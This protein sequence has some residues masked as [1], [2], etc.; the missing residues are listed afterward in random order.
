VRFDATVAGRVVRVEVRGRGPRYSVT[1]EGR[2][3][4]VEVQETST[5]FVDLV[6]DG[7]SHEAGV[8]AREGGCSVLLEGRTLDVLLEEGG[9]APATARRPDGRT[10]RITAPMPGRLLK[11]LV[12]T[13][14]EVTEG[15]GLV[16]MEAMKM[17]NELRAPRAG[18]V[19]ELPALDRQA[20]ESGALL[21][22]LE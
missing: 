8:L 18:R 13:G 7:S 21:V 4:D 10:A 19:K 1:V 5:G 16:V 2:T 17:E 22:V 12:E 20:V 14:Q 11:V 9:A 15:Q 3:M 6:I